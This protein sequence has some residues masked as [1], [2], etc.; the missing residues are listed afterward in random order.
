M[1]TRFQTIA[2]KP[3]ERTKKK[4]RKTGGLTKIEKM[5]ER[6]KKAVGEKK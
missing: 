1:S 3:N 4:E 6:N 2:D 5:R